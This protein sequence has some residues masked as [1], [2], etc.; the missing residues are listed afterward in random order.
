MRDDGW[1]N[2]KPGDECAKDRFWSHRFGQIKTVWAGTTDH[3]LT[4]WAARASIWEH[5]DN[6]AGD[7]AENSSHTYHNTN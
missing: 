6:N 4:N 3:S 1:E 7:K 5:F 2:A